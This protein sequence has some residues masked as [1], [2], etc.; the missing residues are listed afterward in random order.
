MSYNTDEWTIA[1]MVGIS[2]LIVCVAAVMYKM[3][4]DRDAACRSRGGIPYTTFHQVGKLSHL[5]HVCLKQD[6]VIGIP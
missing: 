5:E 6:A 1:G 2:I 3:S 4:K